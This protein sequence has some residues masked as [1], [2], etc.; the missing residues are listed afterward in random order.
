MQVFNESDKSMSNVVIIKQK[1][2]GKMFQ[3]FY[4]NFQIVCADAIK[5]YSEMQIIHVFFY[6][7]FPYLQK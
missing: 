7:Y 2:E 5:F 6:F 3:S 4:F 1:I